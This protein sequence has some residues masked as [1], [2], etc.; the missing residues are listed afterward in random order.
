[1]TTTEMSKNAVIDN[2][3]VEH[4]GEIF[5]GQRNLYS[6]KISKEMQ[7]AIYVEKQNIK[8]NI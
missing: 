4:P 6:L 1:M 3:I 2:T 7:N 8:S 5:H